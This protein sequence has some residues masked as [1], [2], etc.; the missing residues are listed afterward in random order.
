MWVANSFAGVV[1]TLT[2]MNLKGGIVVH[3]NCGD[4]K[5]T[6][7]LQQNE[8]LLVQGLSSDPQQ[9]E[10]A[11]AFLAA[12]GLHGQ[13][14]VGL[15]DGKK[16]PYADN[17]VNL[18][19]ADDA[20]QVS[21]EELLRVLVPLG[22]AC[23]NGQKITKPWPDGIDD[24][25]HFLHDPDNNAVVNDEEVGLPRSLQWINGQK[26][27]RSHEEFST[28]S[29][30]VSSG[31]KLFYIV[32]EAPMAYVSF[33]AE[34]K[35]VARDAFNGRLLW[36]KPVGNWNDHMR[37]FRSG[38]AH[39]PRR[40]VAVDDR[41]YVTLGLDAPL[42]ELD[43]NTG[44]TLQE[45][46]DTK[47][48]EEILA[49]DG[50]LYLMV[51]SSEMNRF[52]G[53]LQDREVARMDDRYMMAIDAKSGRELWRK[54]AKDREYVLPLSMAL[55]N[56][57]IY[58]HSVRGLGCLDATTGKEK[59][60]VERPTVAGRYGF[61]SSTLVATPD[62][63]LLADQEIPKNPGDKQAVATGDL[64]WGVHGWNVESKDI[65]A[66]ITRHGK[67]MLTAYS[68]VDGKKLWDTPCTEGYNSPVDVFVIKDIVWN[69]AFKK[70]PSA[71][72]SGRDLRTGEVVRTL[73]MNAPIVG[74]PHHRCYRDKASINYLFTGHDGIEVH[75]VEKGWVRNNSW[76]RGPCQFGI[77]PC[78]GLM[79][80]PTD[81]CACHLKMRMPGFK[82]YSSQRLESVGKPFS[83]AGRLTKGPAFGQLAKLAA[84]STSDRDWLLYRG[85]IERSGSTKEMVS[86]NNA[87]WRT[88][89]GGNLT[90]PVSAHGR[91]YVA[92]S[93][94]YAVY[95]LDAKTGKKLWRHLAGSTIDSSPTIYNGM[96]IFGSAD[97]QVTCL[98]AGT[99]ELAWRFAAAPEERLISVYG[100]F[101]SSWP[102]HGSIIVKNDE[103]CFTAGSS[104][105][106]SGG[107]YYYRLDPVTGHVLGTGVVSHIDPETE[108][109]TGGKE[110][111][112]DSEGVSHDILSSDGDV[113]YLKH[114]QINDDGTFGTAAK[115]HLFSPTSLL[116]EEWYVRSYW[117]YAKG[118]LGAGYSGWTKTANKNPAGRVL[119]FND[120][121]VFGYG[122][123][124]HKGGP[125]GHH[126]NQYHL[127]ASPKQYAAPVAIDRK[128]AAPEAK[129]KKN[130]KSKAAE[131]KKT[132]EWSETSPFTVR[133][134]VVTPNALLVAG[135]PDLGER[136]DPIDPK[137]QPEKYQEQKNKNP[138]LEFKDPVAA[139]EAF[140]GERGSYLR[141]ISPETGKL[142][143][144]IKLSGT[145]VNDGMAVA[146]GQLFISLKDG[147]VASYGN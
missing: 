56:G 21:K 66:Y 144:E 59:W 127:F 124:D 101:E 51:G 138:R 119:T 131:V 39:L 22:T 17:L 147:S 34:W 97:G 2:E 114:L 64:V 52:G 60:L 15:F 137:T 24:W 53:G 62:V 82:S 67:C 79:Y 113:V 111:N 8:N 1:D 81:P 98:N 115:P 46:K 130:K 6:A 100:R 112:F 73:N 42:V 16:L 25:G 126:N 41:V 86:L 55:S 146:K 20:G 135:V 19:V 11:R 125:V 40:L 92:S 18:I 128:G 123:I 121:T 28:I 133:A 94:E 7:L 141:V 33:N 43:A 23:I 29:V 83:E 13:V 45:Y 103:L 68:T 129:G 120:D 88:E 109:Q 134:M 143:K 10:T 107:I 108:R 87:L 142:E 70:G 37:Q 14:T 63:V 57:S 85:D 93:D 77:M 31:G 102:V 58:Y 105:Y 71:T 54:N 47:W 95:C 12:E 5:E 3:L 49:K 61:S 26:W 44:E 32:D 72:A 117:T 36:E 132:Y 91:V 27:A 136:P 145:P 38:P 96:L 65:K 75:D 48:C 99:G 89:L 35:L 76:T 122:R 84:I 106:L 110:S 9:V 4:A 78:N 140:R 104:S 90:Q 50:T 30:A 116:D 118:I 69:G 74:M 80:A 139:L